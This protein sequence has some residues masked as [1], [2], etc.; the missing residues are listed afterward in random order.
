MILFSCSQNEKEDKPEQKETPVEKIDRDSILQDDVVEENLDSIDCIDTLELKI[1]EYGLVDI[2][3]LDSTI[4]VDLKYASEDNF[5]GINL[6]GNLKRAYL[7]PD[8]AQRLVKAQLKL[9]SIDS[10]K[11]LLVYDGVRPRSVQWKMWNTL[12]TLPP[13]QRGMFVSNP[14]NGSLHNFGAAVD[15]TIAEL[16]GTPL[17]MGA[18]YD[19]IRKIAYPSLEKA[20]LDSG[21]LTKE[22]IANRNLLRQAMRAGG[23][24]G[25]QS[26]WWHFNSCKR[27]SAWAKYK[28][29]E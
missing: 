3:S 11:T 29:V 10:T 26:E 1:L 22:H 5:L 7:Q 12:D 13:R 28:I 23:F 24:W 19:D 25:I 18:G 15:L 8:V 27:D 16:D 14:R 6:Y 9:K 17:D 20:Y 21:M 2:Q 4:L